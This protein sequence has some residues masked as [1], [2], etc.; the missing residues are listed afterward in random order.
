MEASLTCAVCLSVFENPTTLPVCSHNFCKKC[1]L[2]C[3][4]KSFCSGFGLG[5][6]SSGSNNI[7]R[8]S[9]LECPLCRK[10]NF[11]A[12]GA[13][14]LP[15]NTTLAEVVKL[16]RSQHC[17]GGGRKERCGELEENAGPG[18]GARNP[19]EG[20]ALCDRHPSRSLQ[21]FCKVCK[22][23]ACGQCVSEHHRGVFHSVNLIDMIY[24]EEKLEYFNN[25]RE[26]RQLNER[27]KAEVADVPSDIELIL[28]Y[29]KELVENKFDE[30]SEKLE[31]KRTQLLEKIEKQIECKK[32]ERIACLTRKRTQKDTVEKYLKDCERLVNECNPVHFLKVACDLN[33]RVR[34]NL[35]IVLPTL[36]K[37]N[38]SACLQ[39]CQFHIE[40]V[41]DSISALQLAKGTAELNCALGNGNSTSQIVT[42]GYRF[43][44]PLKMWKRPKDSE[45]PKFSPET[46]IDFLDGKQNHHWCLT[47]KGEYQ[48]MSLEEVRYKYYQSYRKDWNCFMNEKCSSDVNSV[49]PS[50]SSGTS[51]DILENHDGIKQH[52][53]KLFSFGHSSK[54]V[55]KKYLGKGSSNLELKLSHDLGTIASKPS[56]SNTGISLSR[57]FTKL[58][59]VEDVPLPYNSGA[60]I[61]KSSVSN[62]ER[63]CTEQKKQEDSSVPSASVES[64][65]ISN[66]PSVVKTLPTTSVTE[67][68]PATSTS[69]TAVPVFDKTDEHQF[70][71]TPAFSSA[72]STETKFSESPH[73]Q[74]VSSNSN[75]SKG[76]VNP[77]AT[78]DVSHSSVLP[79][80]S[81]IGKAAYRNLATKIENEQSLFSSK[82]SMLDKPSESS[83][84]SSTVTNLTS[85]FHNNITC[86]S[87]GKNV[88]HDIG[89]TSTVT[90]AADNGKDYSVGTA[91]AF[92]FAKTAEECSPK[93]SSKSPFCLNT[94][95]PLCDQNKTIPQSS[96]LCSKTEKP[97]SLYTRIPN[98]QFSAK[99]NK[100]SRNKKSS[101]TTGLV[102]KGDASKLFVPA[103]SCS[104][105]S[106]LND[107]QVLSFDKSSVFKCEG[108]GTVTATSS[109]F[110]SYSY[111][112]LFAGNFKQAPSIKPSNHS[113]SSSEMSSVCSVTD[114]AGII[115]MAFTT[116]FS[117][118][119]SAVSQQQSIVKPSDFTKVKKDFEVPIAAEPSKQNNVHLSDSKHEDLPPA[120]SEQQ[121]ID[122]TSTNISFE[123]CKPKEAPQ[124]EKW[125]S[126]KPVVL[127]ETKSASSTCVGFSKELSSAVSQQQTNVATP[128]AGVGAWK[129]KETAASEVPVSTQR[130]GTDEESGPS[131]QPNSMPASLENLLE[132][133]STNIEE[134]GKESP[135]FNDQIKDVQELHSFENPGHTG[136]HQSPAPSNDIFLAEHENSTSDTAGPS[137]SPARQIILEPPN[138]SSHRKEFAFVPQSFASKSNSFGEANNSTKPEA[139]RITSADC[140]LGTPTGFGTVFAFGAGHGFQFKPGVRGQPFALGEKGDKGDCKTGPKPMFPFPPPVNHPPT[141]VTAEDILF[142]NRAK[143]YYYERTSLQWKERAFG[144]IRILQHKTTKLPRLVMWNS[145]NKCCAN[146]WIT[147]NLELKH[148][149]NSSHSWTWSALDYSGRRDI[150]LDLAVHF[151]LK[152]TGQMFKEVF[153][154]VQSTTEV[155]KSTENS[156]CCSAENNTSDQNGVF[157]FA[158]ASDSKEG[159]SLQDDEDVV[160]LS[161]VTPTPE[162]KA[163]ALKLLLPPTFFCYKNKPGYQSSDD[164]DEN[165][166]TAIR[167]LGGQLYPNQN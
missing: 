164:E 136:V 64:A 69:C 84:T 52:P 102:R 34:S 166:E 36:K 161:E 117:Q 159:K 59:I 41:L 123:N 141:M 46:I 133:F 87:S 99:S 81:T 140:P 167:K 15:S 118:Q 156:L 16:F 53:A 13:V 152:E 62:S 163:L 6:C 7:W 104:D 151:K 4:T 80:S 79:S 110:T 105:V 49:N 67:S 132:K 129:V 8:N 109:L 39:P 57:N 90:S 20:Y 127:Q 73:T 40:P 37:H 3:V 100:S 158:V 128:G 50:V 88:Q 134:R 35:A 17:E 31:L 27:L 12:E 101:S 44:T 108:P 54:K 150:Y 74:N 120:V 147:S 24:Q 66:I 72:G 10:T 29:E 157:S 116:C 61:T 77:T 115:P 45:G 23:V 75:I 93:S 124:T 76:P 2:E 119:L 68:C 19:G 5:I 78:S 60:A 106:N 139:I 143:L 89:Q 63:L 56:T 97:K 155:S 14:N 71:R 145:A 126:C 121:S 9:Q 125:L 26:L 138:L 32:A 1:I 70:F 21:L 135:V 98:A 11:I 86:D 149:K 25:L 130:P 103:Q 65:I 153:E 96:I 58:P 162:Q 137:F 148:S 55:K 82:S 48:D 18:A 131:L 112:S 142:S 94:F 91:S 42:D 107:K 43:K 22:Q 113:T 85:V 95:G 146:H 30:I 154:S 47:S 83:S 160:I 165:F 114:S 92:F 122:K 33:E 51:T 111:S 28:E 144:E 38:E